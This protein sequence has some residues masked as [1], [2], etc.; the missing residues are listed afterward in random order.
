[1]IAAILHGP[2][3]V[4]LEERPDPEPGPGE[5]VIAV[6]AALTCGTDRKAFRYG[7]P[8]Y[9]AAGGAF[10]H[11]FAGTVAAVGAGVARFAVGQRVVAADSAPCQRCFHCQRGA[12]ALCEDLEFAFGGFGQLL[13]LPRRVVAINLHPI[14]PAVPDV[15][16]ALCEPLACA[17]KAVR[18]AD[19]RDGDRVAVLGCGP[20]GLMLVGLL[21][22]L[23]AE[24]V[25]V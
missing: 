9:A 25:A 20:L 12:F 6:T 14:P 4:R 11:E 17:V 21:G 19:V 23:G 24:V 10:G 3:D 22:Q 2:G 8:A 18:Q 7:H 15:V 13:R 5:V 1:M 16:A